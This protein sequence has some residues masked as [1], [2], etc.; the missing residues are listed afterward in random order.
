MGPP[1]S[2]RLPLPS[3]QEVGLGPDMEMRQDVTWTLSP[4]FTSTRW[5][6]CSLWPQESHKASKGLLCWSQASLA[7]DTILHRPPQAE[8]W[9]Q[10]AAQ[11]PG[12]CCR[13]SHTSPGWPPN[14]LVC[15][16][17]GLRSLPDTQILVPGHRWWR[18]LGIHLYRS[19]PLIILQFHHMLKPLM[20]LVIPGDQQEGGDSGRATWF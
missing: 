20:Q 8:V 17:I 4:S 18:R 15:S 2:Y 16:P 12:P 5:P 7:V 19:S 6:A 13:L 9:T 1:G 10:P 11:K 3:A 14:L